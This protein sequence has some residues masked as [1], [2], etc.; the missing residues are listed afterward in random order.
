[1]DTLLARRARELGKTVKELAADAGLTRTYLYKLVSG[2]TQDPSIRTLIR[3]AVAL[4]ISPIQLFRYFG[5]D[6]ESDRHDVGLSRQLVRAEGIHNANDSIEFTADVTVPDHSI[7]HVGESFR[8]IWKVQNTGRIPWRKRRLARV[9][10]QYV[11]ARRR[12]DGSLLPLVPNYLTSL[13]NSVPIAETLPGGIAEI[14]VDF[15]A[16]PERCSVA[17]IWRMEC[18]SGMACFP[19]SFFLQVVVTVVSS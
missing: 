11:I 13:T 8:K 1:M 2:D 16:P 12:E 6:D 14:S 5:M 17:S 15:V 3:L 18:D 9:D 10:E 19:S 4:K 7:V